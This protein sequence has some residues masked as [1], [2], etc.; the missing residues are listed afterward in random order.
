MVVVGLGFG[1]G[2][3]RGSGESRR[4]KPR[5]RRPEPALE[6]ERTGQVPSDRQHQPDHE[7]GAPGQRQDRQGRQG[8][9]SG[10][11]LRVHQLHHQRVWNLIFYLFFIFDWCCYVGYRFLR[12]LI[13]KFFFFFWWLRASDKCQREKRKT[14]NGDD[15]LWAMATL[16]FE[17]YID[18]LKV[19]LTR[20]REVIYVLFVFC[21][22]LCVKVVAFVY[23]SLLYL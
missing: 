2:D 3:G 7:E 17:D 15:L 10:M 9:C 21:S 23:I 22:C 11:C 4:R 16:G 20:Y 13:G 14:I 1:G 12:E 18:P 8:D 6:R 19:Y 5:E